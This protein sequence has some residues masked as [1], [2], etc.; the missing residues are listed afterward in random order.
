MSCPESA[1]DKHRAGPRDGHGQGHGHGHGHGL[2]MAMGW[3]WARHGDRHGLG[4]AMG[5][6]W[7]LPWA[8]QEDRGTRVSTGSSRYIR[9]R[10][11]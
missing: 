10:Y 9:A 7:A 2:G 5:M 11:F 4:M 3:A 6:G 1:V 8:W